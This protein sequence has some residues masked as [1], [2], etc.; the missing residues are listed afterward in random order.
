[1]NMQPPVE[2]HWL[3]PL[4]ISVVLFTLIGLLYV[5]IGVLAPV[6]VRSGTVTSGIL[7][8]SERTDTLVFGQNPQELLRNNPNL[9]K[10]RAILMHMLAGMCAA[11]GVCYL[12]VVWFGL[13]AG[14]GWA[15]AVLAVAGVAVLPFWVIA[16]RPY[17]QPSV[18]LT[19][20]DVPPFMWVPALLWLPAVLL[21]RIGLP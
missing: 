16:L 19:L 1:M 14:Q 21:G 11:L 13:R 5:L 2:F 6:F 17:L 9:G 18:N 20:G 7:I 3:S 8:V 10:S 4:G 12:A 15:L